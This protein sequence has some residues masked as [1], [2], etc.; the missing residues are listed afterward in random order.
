MGANGSSIAQ[1]KNDFELVIR[2]TKE[3]EFLLETHFGAPAGKDSGGLH[4]KITMARIPAT[5]APLPKDVVRRMRKLV[6]IRNALVHDREVN[7][8]DRTEFRQG[9]LAVERELKDY[10]PRPGGTACVI[11]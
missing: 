9:W 1:C 10:L 7:E 4:D 6:T 2:A 5:G 8:I 11:C 3:L